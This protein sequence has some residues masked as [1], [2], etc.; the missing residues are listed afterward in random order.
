MEELVRFSAR[1]QKLFDSITSK[2]NSVQ[3]SLGAI[4]NDETKDFIFFRLRSKIE[5]WLQDIEATLRDLTKEH[6]QFII[7]TKSNF[8]FDQSSYFEA[9]KILEIVTNNIQRCN[10]LLDDAYKMFMNATYAQQH[11]YVLSKIEDNF[12]EKF[13]AVASISSNV[14]DLASRLNILQDQIK[15]MTNKVY[16]SERGMQDFLNYAEDNFI[17]VDFI[18]KVDLKIKQISKDIIEINE[19]IKTPSFKSY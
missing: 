9:N 7:E 15:E 4:V 17:T 12:E 6:G 1:A 2:I 19:K 16:K 3:V 18:E 10:N 5:T 8:A 14:F 13:N 11:K